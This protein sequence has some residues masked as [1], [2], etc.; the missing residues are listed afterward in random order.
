ML[1]KR[2]STDRAKL[3][4]IKVGDFVADEF[5]KYGKVSNIEKIQYK[6]EIHYYFY[7]DKAGTILIIT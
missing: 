4:S 3:E 6:K 2:S 1:I 5:G 7:L